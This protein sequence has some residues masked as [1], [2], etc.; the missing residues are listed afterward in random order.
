VELQEFSQ[1]Q[2][3]FT[4]GNID[5][6]TPLAVNCYLP[7]TTR[8]DGESAGA[9]WRVLPAEKVPAGAELTNAK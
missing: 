3:Q 8:A 4:A 7:P 6:G 9:L 1:T 2:L 5:T